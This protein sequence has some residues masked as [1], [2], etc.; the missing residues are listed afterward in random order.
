MSDC[1]FEIP[2]T[3]QWERIKGINKTYINLKYVMWLKV[4]QIT[5]SKGDGHR[6]LSIAFPNRP[7]VEFFDYGNLSADD[8]VVKILA[9]LQEAVKNYKE[10]K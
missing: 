3:N 8:E 1:F 5:T 10:G 7:D 9:D 2:S 6:Y 4:K